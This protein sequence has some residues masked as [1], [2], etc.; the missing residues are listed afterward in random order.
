M[1]ACANSWDC[2]IERN[3]VVVPVYSLH[4]DCCCSDDFSRAD[5]GFVR[6]RRC[7][8][9][10]TGTDALDQFMESLTYY[11]AKAKCE[12]IAVRLCTKDEYVNDYTT[13]K[14]SDVT[15]LNT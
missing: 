13:D 1:V 5:F 11:N 10:V 2:R 9:L 6:V 14:L 4:G 8:I 12:E 15:Y 7:G 3:P